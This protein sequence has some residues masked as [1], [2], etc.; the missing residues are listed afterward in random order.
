MVLAANDGRSID[1]TVRCERRQTGCECVRAV[2]SSF[3]K[4][5][6]AEFYVGLPFPLTLLRNVLVFGETRAKRSSNN[7]VVR[8]AADRRTDSRGRQFCCALR[9]SLSRI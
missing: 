1:T 5:A 6:I 2:I 3:L 8:S 4:A 7:T 9:M